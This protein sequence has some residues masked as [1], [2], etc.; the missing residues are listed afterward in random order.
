MKPIGDLHQEHDDTLQPGPVPKPS[1]LFVCY[2][3]NQPTLKIIGSECSC[4]C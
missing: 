3:Y 4:S 1:V 2:T